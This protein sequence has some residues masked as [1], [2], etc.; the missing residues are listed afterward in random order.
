M[1][2]C[3]IKGGGNFTFTASYFEFYKLGQ[4]QTKKDGETPI[5]RRAFVTDIADRNPRAVSAGWKHLA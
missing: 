5:K 4:P 2:W 1:A 3:L